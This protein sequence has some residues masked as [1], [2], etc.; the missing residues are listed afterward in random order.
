MSLDVSFIFGGLSSEYDASISNLTHI[1]SSYLALPPAERPFSVKHLYHLSRDDSLVRTFP[2]HSAFTISKLQTYISDTSIL[3]GRTL[4]YTFDAI[5]SRNEYVVNLLPGQFGEDGGVQ[6]LAALFGLKGT[7][8]DPQV[9][10][11]AMN[12]HAMSSFVSSLFPA[13]TVKVPKTKL[14]KPRYLDNAIQFAQSLRGPVVAKPNSLGS[15]LF[16]DVFGTFSDPEADIYPLLDK[17]FKYDSAALFQEFIPGDDY[18]CGCIVTSS[19]LIMLPVVKIET[20]RG[21]FGYNE[22]EDSKLSNKKIVDTGDTV[23][24]R[25]K[26]V[27]RII[28]SAIDIYSIARFDFRVTNTSEIYFLECNCIPGLSKDSI[29]TKMLLHHDM[30][31]IDL[32]LLVASHS[33]SFTRKPHLIE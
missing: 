32:I 28:A 21:F 4:P 2:F 31:V 33:N 13:E 3:P 22:K 17:I 30:T 19:E 5:K 20:E 26:S 15:S 27:T 7:F 18:S 8:G 23:S 12:K 10:S 9:A 24:E 29:F 11:L 16:T 25:L 1:I 6:T 14:V